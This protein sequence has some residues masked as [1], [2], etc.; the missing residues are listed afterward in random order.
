MKKEEKMKNEDEKRWIEMILIEIRNRKTGMERV[1]RS[2]FTL[3]HRLLPR[4]SSE[5]FNGFFPSHSSFNTFLPYVSPI[6]RKRHPFLYLN[7]SAITSATPKQLSHIISFFSF[8]FHFHFHQWI[9]RECQNIDG[10]RRI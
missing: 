5:R 10:G 7:L 3:F 8:L 2:I 4:E 9:R 6:S 1:F